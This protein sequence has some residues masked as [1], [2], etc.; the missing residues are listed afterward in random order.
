MGITVAQHFADG[1]PLPLQWDAFYP[2]T[3]RS[4]VILAQPPKSRSY[5]ERVRASEEQ[6]NPAKVDG[7]F[8]EASQRD[9][10]A[11]AARL[12]KQHLETMSAA[13]IEQAA[14]EGGMDGAFVREAIRRISANESSV[15]TPTTA[16]PSATAGEVAVGIS[17][18]LVVFCVF[19]L[20]YIQTHGGTGAPTVLALLIGVLLLIA[21]VYFVARN[22]RVAAANKVTEAARNTYAFG[23]GSQRSEPLNI[24]RIVTTGIAVL[25]LATIPFC[26]F[27]GPA[28]QFWFLGVLSPFIG[29]FCSQSKTAFWKA[30]SIGAIGAV[31]A[32][33][34]TV[35]R[36]NAHLDASYWPVSM[37]ALG[38]VYGLLGLA[39]FG[40]SSRVNRSKT[41]KSHFDRAE[42][43]AQLFELQAA[44]DRNQE[45][46]TFLSV[47]VVNSSAMKASDNELEV[48]YSF[49]QYQAWIAETVRSFGGEIQ[50]A[51][52]DGAMAMFRDPSSAV[53]AA[54]QLQLGIDTFNGSKN[55]LTSPFQIRCGIAEGR[56]GLD[57]R[58]PIGQIQSPVLDRAAFLQKYAEPGSVV[59][60]KELIEIAMPVLGSLHQRELIDG[61]PVYCWAKQQ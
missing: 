58:T 52:G 48:E 14:V 18:P 49:R 10:L 27:E 35:F 54:K 47:D 1:Q 42:V 21:A 32:G 24:G 2:N 60:T 41:A 22:G 26:G 51:A 25:T 56:I 20:R 44:L 13:E 5:T 36:L 33:L 23:L 50:L 34:E 28:A 19:A 43:L 3:N 16:S 55:R 39:G 6:L 53:S 30:A 57:A 61:R 59:V 12:H 17:V 46:R 15:E 7:R 40:V 37:T 4:L 45:T 31:L 29:G 9:V 38:T 11:L 8:D